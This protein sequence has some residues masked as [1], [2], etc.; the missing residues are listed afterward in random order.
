M[1]DIAAQADDIDTFSA[2]LDLTSAELDRLEH[3][4]ETAELNFQ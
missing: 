2:A 1:L 3:F 4:F